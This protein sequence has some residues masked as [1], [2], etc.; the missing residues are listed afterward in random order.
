M[1]FWLDGIWRPIASSSLPEL[2]RLLAKSRAAK[3]DAPFA[4]AVAWEVI[5]IA[6]KV[7]LMRSGVVSLLVVAT[8][9]RCGMAPQA[10]RQSEFDGV[11]DERT[12]HAAK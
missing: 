3:D 10:F 9:V 2:I 11:E 5:A 8:L 7:R 1:H 4:C 6:V 12:I